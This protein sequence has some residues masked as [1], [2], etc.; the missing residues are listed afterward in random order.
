MMEVQPCSLV[1]AVEALLHARDSPSHCPT[2]YCE[3][4]VKIPLIDAGMTCTEWPADGARAG[5]A[6]RWSASNPGVVRRPGKVL[7]PTLH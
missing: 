4:A 7:L 3:A 5:C 2:T 6:S 1:L